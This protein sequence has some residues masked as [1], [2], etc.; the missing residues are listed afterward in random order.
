MTWV[1]VGVTVVGAAGSAISASS[2]N[3]RA[4]AAAGGL[5]GAIAYARSNP[6]AFG[7]KLKFEGVDYSPL[8]KT[9]PGYGNI[10]GD[11]IAG[12]QRNLGANQIGRAH[13]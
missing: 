11:V 13:V 5:D 9:D 8:F 7:E 3:K 10:A 2:A 1:A 4:K 6:S 12:N